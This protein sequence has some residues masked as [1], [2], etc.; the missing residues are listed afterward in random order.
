[1]RS[2]ARKEGVEVYGCGLPFSPRP[3]LAECLHSLAR[4]VAPPPSA[5][6]AAANRCIPRYQVPSR[7]GKL[8]REAFSSPICSYG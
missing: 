3:R 1:M 8:G 2:D 5:L 4:A 7:F 6:H